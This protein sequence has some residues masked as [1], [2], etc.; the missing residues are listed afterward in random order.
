L[1]L[2]YPKIEDNFFEDIGFYLPQLKYLSFNAFKI[3]DNALNSI[4]KLKKLNTI[5]I[6]GH[7]GMNWSE[8]TDTALHYLINNCPQIKSIQFSN[9]T[10]ITNKTI[11]QLMAS[12]TKPSIQCKHRFHTNYKFKTNYLPII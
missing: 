2:F 5:S 3:R 7:F 11:E 8:I 4:S 9:R 1:Y 6:E 10:N 12:Q